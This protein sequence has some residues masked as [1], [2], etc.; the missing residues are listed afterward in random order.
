M[1]KAVRLLLLVLFGFVPAAFADV[2]FY[3]L[4]NY[5]GPEVK[6]DVGMYTAQDLAK[7]GIPE[8]AINSIKVPDGF[9]V[10]LFENDGFGG[11]YG[12]L[13]SSDACLEDDNF[14]KLVSSLTISKT[15]SSFGSTP[16][17]VIS[18]EPHDSRLNST[19]RALT[20]YSECNYKGRSATVGVG[21]FNNAQLNKLGISNNSI[22]SIKVGK[23]FQA[24]LYINDFHRGRSG[25][26]RK[27]YLLP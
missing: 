27:K 12:T 21:E 20:V 1:K 6:L 24:D 4:C 17:V 3:G 26:L 2:S 16:A 10:T 15:E 14:D 7:Q 25:T 11:R 23:G 9:T 5:Q 8:D 13:K 19:R 22:S 18:E